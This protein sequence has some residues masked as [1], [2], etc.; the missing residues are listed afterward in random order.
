MHESLK[1]WAP[2]YYIKQIKSALN[3]SL[4]ARSVTRTRDL[5]ISQ[6]IKDALFKSPYESGAPTD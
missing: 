4:D 2:R 6:E 1:S 3:K 5:Q